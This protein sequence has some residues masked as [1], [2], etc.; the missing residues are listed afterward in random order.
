MRTVF[1]RIR[2]HKRLLHPKK[3]R[4]GLSSVEYTG[5][6]L[7]R[8]GLSFSPEK[9]RTLLDFP[10][11][12]RKQQL[13]QFLSLANYIRDHSTI[14]AALQK[15]LGNYSKREQHT[16]LHL[17]ADA[18]SA[19]ALIKERIQ[20]CPKLFFVDNQSPIHLYTD[21]S[22]YGIGGYLVQLVHD[23]VKKT[24][25]HPIAFM[26]SALQGGPL[27]WEIPQKESFAIF[28]AIKKFEYLLRD[29]PFVIHTDH[30]NITF[31]NT[32]FLSQ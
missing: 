4:I 28:A 15:H 32:S 13:K 21:A 16:P 19:F 17:D 3:A 25:E 11:P 2:K 9:I 8:T 10:L 31:L 6:V 7:D 14:V 18:I 20:N 1:A 24:V 22:T 26:S 29:R 12:L 23:P 5:Q 27:K 30:K